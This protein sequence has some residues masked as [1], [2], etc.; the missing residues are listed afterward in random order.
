M[1]MFF[2]MEVYYSFPPPRNTVNCQNDQAVL[3]AFLDKA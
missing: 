3:L 1:A 2:N